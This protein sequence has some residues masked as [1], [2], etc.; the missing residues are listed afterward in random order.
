MA[1]DAITGSQRAETAER[2]HAFTMVHGFYATMGGYAVEFVDEKGRFIGP[3]FLPEGQRRVSLTALGVQFLIEH[4]PSLIPD[5]SERSIRG[6]IGLQ[7]AS[8]RLCCALN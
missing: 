5:L 7:V 6:Q 4:D 2:Y 8:A 3:N 1:E